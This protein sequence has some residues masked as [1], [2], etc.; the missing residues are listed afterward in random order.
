[1]LNIMVLMGFKEVCTFAQ[2]K[3]E[4]ADWYKV[5]ANLKL[6]IVNSI[7]V[8]ALLCSGIWCILKAIGEQPNL[9]F[10]STFSS[11]YIWY[12]RNGHFS[13]IHIQF[14]TIPVLCETVAKY[15]DLQLSFV[16]IKYLLVSK[17]SWLLKW[18][19]KV[20]PL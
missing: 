2:S 15:G 7:N 13:Y 10:L 9:L 17:Y 11:T 16:I 3:Q 5:M 18:P 12:T 6:V 20:S 14:E 4:I 1:M 19:P 8:Y